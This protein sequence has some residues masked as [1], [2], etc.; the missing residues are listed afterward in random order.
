M[1]RHRQ[2]VMSSTRSRTAL[3]IVTFRDA[4]TGANVLPEGNT[5]KGVSQ[6]ST[7]AAAK[8]GTFIKN[9]TSGCTNTLGCACIAN[10]VDSASGE[11]GS[12]SSSGFVST[13]KSVNVL[14]KLSAD[15]VIAHV[16]ANAG[17]VKLTTSSKLSVGTAPT[18]TV[19]SSLS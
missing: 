17:P 15:E 1:T 13:I 19:C 10:S 12:G 6:P 3:R 8:V 2:K 4:Y 14:T 16:K 9:A 18:T 7:D 11:L 5:F